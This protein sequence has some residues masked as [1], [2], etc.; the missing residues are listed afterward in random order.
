MLNQCYIFYGLYIIILFNIFYKPVLSCMPGY[1][2]ERAKIKQYLGLEWVENGLDKLDSKKL[3]PIRH[4][5]DLNC[6]FQNVETCNWKNVES[7]EGLDSMDFFLFTKTDH[8]EFPYLRVA[9]G[10]SKLSEGDNLLF[11]GDRKREEQTAI[12]RSSLIPCQKNIGKLTLDYWTYNGARLEVLMYE[13]LPD[14]NIKLIPEKLYLD[15][16]TVY[17]NTECYV[18]I[19]ERNTPFYIAI[20]GYDMAN[21]EGSFVMV[22]N[23]KY[24]AELCK[25][26]LDLGEDF[27]GN[28]LITSANGDYISTPSDLSCSDWNKKCR[29]R[30]SISGNGIWK[31]AKKSPNESNLYN[32]TGTFNRPIKNFVYLYIEQYSKGPFVML[33]SDPIQCQSNEKSFI[34]FRTWASKN[35]QLSIC[36]FTLAK[37]KLECK[38]I[39]LSQT[40][41]PIKYHFRPKKNFMYGIKI[42]NVDQNVDNFIAIDDIKYSATLCDDAKNSYDYGNDFYVTELLSTIVNRPLHTTSDLNCDF[43]KRGLDC[44]WGNDDSNNNVLWQIGL[45]NINIHKFSSLTGTNIL[46]DGE[47]GIANFTKP[48]TAILL[49]EIIKC[50]KGDSSLTL[51]Y[52]QTGNAI[53]KVCLIDGRKMTI[54]DCQPVTINQPG[55]IIID[56]PQVTS[57]FR[58]SFYAESSSQGTIIV[59]D[60]K[61]DGIICSSTPITKYPKQS[62]AFAAITQIFSKK[63]IEIPDPNVCR[64]LSCDFNQNSTCLFTSEHLPSSKSEF[65]LSNKAMW[66]VL[67]KENYIAMLASPIFSLNTQGRFHFDYKIYEGNVDIFVCQDSVKRSFD[68]C[69]KVSSNTKKNKEK[70]DIDN[71]WKHEYVDILPSDIRLYIVVK[72]SEES[73][74][75]RARIAIDNLILRDVENNDIC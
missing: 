29:W 62:K 46:P 5:S 74:F 13:K 25:V 11:I 4:S 14:D 12:I 60:I 22:D 33:V 6:D 73:L 39:M 43:V 51:K 2:Q 23:I 1:E 9:P 18:N 56:I 8:I 53:L 10:P 40:P 21:V 35:V 54:I 66:V 19:P 69:F 7:K 16:G 26:A 47:F 75:H 50:T 48:G 57:P 44:V 15:C 70:Y 71:N 20:R 52:W 31:M 61:M 49:S 63:I 37:E 17:L 24:E 38:E 67:S 68:T 58:L 32:I 28:D 41:A 65:I 36:A 72:F 42:D 3:R 45:G 64:L 34:Q 59:D 30:N 55:P 27:E